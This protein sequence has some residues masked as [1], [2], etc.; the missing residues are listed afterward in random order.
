MTLECG[1]FNSKADKVSIDRIDS[2]I[3][4][5]DPNQMVE[6]FYLIGENKIIKYIP[7][8][9]DSIDDPRISHHISFK[10]ISVY[11][12]KAVALKKI[13]G[14]EPPKKITYKPDT[15]IITFYFNWA[16]SKEYL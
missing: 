10:G 15:T 2:L 11:Q 12:S 4:S 14:I 5:N 8:L 1:R 13:S 16:K 3:F 7:E 6:G 9:L